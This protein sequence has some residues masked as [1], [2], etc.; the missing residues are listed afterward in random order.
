[1]KNKA[2]MGALLALLVF[3]ILTG[4]TST[5]EYSV[6][7]DSF[8]KDFADVHVSIAYLD[9]EELLARH[10]NDGNAFIDFPANLGQKRLMVFE[11]KVDT[12]DTS[13]KI[14][15]KHITLNYGGKV[16]SPLSYFLLEEMWKP[17]NKSSMEAGVRGKMAGQ[18]V[19]GGTLKA[20]P[21]KPLS[22]Y[23]VFA[24]NFPVFGDAVFT[25][26]ISTSD[27]TDE[28]YVEAPFQF[29]PAGGTVQKGENAG[30]EE[31]EPSK[32][33]IFNS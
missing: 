8:E 7:G 31:G 14:K 4:C 1:M 11:L 24:K 2:E 5:R 19:S 26:P 33:S 21:G 23:I 18:F 32:K 15:H 20:G 29:R 16:A 30:Q 27:G 12:V 9:R 3:L 13:I 6:T 25:M 22:V 28:G 17:F 10:G